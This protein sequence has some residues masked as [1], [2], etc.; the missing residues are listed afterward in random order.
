MR[1]KPLSSLLSAD[2]QLSALTDKAMQ[3]ARMQQVLVREAP[4]GI[5]GIAG[6]ARMCT[7]ANFRNGTVVIHAANNAVAAK[8]RLVLPRLLAVF[9]EMRADVKAVRIELQIPETPT[10]GSG[11]PCANVLSARAGDHLDQLAERLPESPLRSVVYALAQRSK[12]TSGG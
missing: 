1:S 4:A 7:V 5:A 12:P 6:I 9:Q 8:M 3:L 2:A 11:Q 10:I